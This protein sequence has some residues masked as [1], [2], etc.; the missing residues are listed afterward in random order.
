M[1]KKQ[2]FIKIKL[3]DISKIWAQEEQGS[4]ET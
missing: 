4:D 3:E 2:F 1:G